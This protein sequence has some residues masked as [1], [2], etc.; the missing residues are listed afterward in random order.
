MSKT[1]V[2]NQIAWDKFSRLSAVE[3]A[4]YFLTEGRSYHALVAQQ[5]SRTM[6]EKLP[7]CSTCALI[8]FIV[9]VTPASDCPIIVHSSESPANTH[10]PPS[11]LESKPS[12]AGCVINSRG[13]IESFTIIML[14]DCVFVPFFPVTVI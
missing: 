8:P 12:P 4:P 7:S 14:A 13:G 6:L 5:F 3:K 11:L 10:P 1:A 9:S 2:L